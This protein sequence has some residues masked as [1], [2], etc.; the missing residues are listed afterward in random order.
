VYNYD[1]RLINFKKEDIMKTAAK[2][3]I[4][5]ALFSFGGIASPVFSQSTAESALSV[6]EMAANF[7]KQKTRGLALVTPTA[8]VTNTSTTEI[9]A[10]D[11]TATAKIAEPTLTS[12]AVDDIA[13][14][15]VPKSEQVNINISFDFDSA[16]LRPDQAPKLVTLCSALIAADVKSIRILGH[17]DSSGSAQYNE[18]LSKL[19]AVE[20]KRHLANDCDI[21]PERMEAVGVG[22]RI[23]FDPENPR[24]DANRRVEF[25]ALS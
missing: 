3:V 11:T 6:E 14:A 18:R 21:A 4:G 16:A 13:I 23:P 22:E 10:T 15:I 5:I 1:E 7:K 2:V 12:I 24:A 25:Q 17:T 19:R 9:T 8:K 20:V